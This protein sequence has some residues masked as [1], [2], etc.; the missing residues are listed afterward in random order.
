MPYRFDNRS[1][2]TNKN[3]DA[4]FTIAIMKEPSRGILDE[5]PFMEKSAKHLPDTLKEAA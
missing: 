1:L 4:G 5:L 2:T 3:L